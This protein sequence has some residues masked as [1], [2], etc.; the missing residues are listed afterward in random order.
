MFVEALSL[1][2]FS[3]HESSSNPCPERVV[4][5]G[6]D[7]GAYSPRSFREFV[8]NHSKANPPWP[9]NVELVENPRTP[10]APGLHSAK[11]KAVVFFAS[12][13]ENAPSDLRSLLRW[14]VP[15]VAFDIPGTREVPH[16]PLHPPFFN[17]LSTPPTF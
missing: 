8:T 10:I 16:P 9:F 11:G 2:A 4:F 14:G 12:Q 5:M 15:T 7:S 6:A 17:F 13:W 1:L 3:C